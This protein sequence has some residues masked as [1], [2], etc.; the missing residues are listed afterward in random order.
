MLAGLAET[1]VEWESIGLSNEKNKPLTKA[2]NSISP[3]LKWMHNPK[4]RAYLKGT[5]YAR[6]S[7]FYSNKCSEFICCQ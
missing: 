5:A 1:I 2:R 3:K 4:I 6:K 7:K